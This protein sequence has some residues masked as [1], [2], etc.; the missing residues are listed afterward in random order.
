MEP[1]WRKEEEKIG[2]KLF[3]DFFFLNQKQNI[4]IL[5]LDISSN[6]RFLTQEKKV[7]KSVAVKKSK[8]QIKEKRKKQT[9][10]GK[11]QRDNKQEQAA[12][13]NLTTKK[14]DIKYEFNSV[15]TKLYETGYS[16][17]RIEK[18]NAA[19]QQDFY[20]PVLTKEGVEEI[21]K[22]TRIKNEYQVDNYINPFLKEKFDSWA[23]INRIDIQLR[24][25][26]EPYAQMLL[27]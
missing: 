20:N 8:K 2:N 22:Q 17:S 7:T 5:V 6:M 4:F 18:N 25:V 10:Q 3:L 14:P 21:I 11:Q 13:L 27:K 26:L 19:A 24:Y 9:K 1:V 16:R 15:K 23:M 12:N